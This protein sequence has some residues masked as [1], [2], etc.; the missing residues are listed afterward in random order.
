MSF[1]ELNMVDVKEVLRRFMAGQ[2][3]RRIAREGVV[4]RKTAQRYLDAAR[5]CG[6][7]L[8]NEPTDEQV[9]QVA[10]VVQARP[11]GERSEGWRALEAEH[12]R[13]KKWLTG[14]KPSTLVRVS[15]LL[16]RD[17]QIK[18]PYTTLRR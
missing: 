7:D 11:K 3:A 5:E 4:D 15:E 12:D 18:V 1:R 8:Q 13:F 17:A 16:A 2:S 6:L 14:E 10:R 9:L